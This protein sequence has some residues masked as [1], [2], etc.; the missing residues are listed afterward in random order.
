[1]RSSAKKV[2]IVGILAALSV[3]LMN[4]WHFPIMPPPFTKMFKLDFADIPALIAASVVSPA[5]GIFVV[6]IRNLV[7]LL[8]SDTLGIGELSNFILG[9]VFSCF[10]GF[11][12]RK[13]KE[14]F[15]SIKTYKLI[16]VMFFA[17]IVEI[18]TA[19]LSNYFIV[20]PLYAKHMNFDVAA[21]GGM[22][23]FIVSGVLP[24]NAIKAGINSIIFVTLYKAL[25]P[26]IKQYL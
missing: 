8:R 14:G 22:K 16:T 2:A 20:L 15:A 3:I 9:S 19:V 1:M 24:F 13:C 7:H 5:C 11:F 12:I 25:V 21:M 23:E 18:I 6:L 26:K 4:I 17:I 10:T